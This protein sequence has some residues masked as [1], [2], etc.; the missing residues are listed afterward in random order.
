MPV[1]KIHVL[2]GRYDEVASAR[3]RPRFKTPLWPP[4]VFRRRTSFRSSMFCRR[5][6]VIALEASPINQYDLLLIKR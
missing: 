1:A 3:S 4:S 2:E 5:V 6:I